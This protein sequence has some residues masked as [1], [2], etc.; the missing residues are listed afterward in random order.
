MTCHITA[1]NDRTGELSNAS[2]YVVGKNTKNRYGKDSVKETCGKSE[3]F[4]RSES[5]YVSFITIYVHAM[6]VD[7]R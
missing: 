2:I 6:R 4:S 3:C 1:H 5:H 7:G